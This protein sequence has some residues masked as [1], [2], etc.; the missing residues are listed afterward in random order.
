MTDSII[1]NRGH[2]YN[3][4]PGPDNINPF[5]YNKLILDGDFV[6]VKKVLNRKLLRHTI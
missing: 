4:P 5:Q 2:R 3:I 6:S 1:A